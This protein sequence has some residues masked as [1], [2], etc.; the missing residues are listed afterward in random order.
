MMTTTGAA[1][2]DFNLWTTF[3]AITLVA[4]M[5]LGGSAGSTAGSVKVVRHLLIGRILRRELD[6]SVHPEIVS[7]VG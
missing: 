4:A 7:R 3:A 1:S 5:F 6:Q 2:A